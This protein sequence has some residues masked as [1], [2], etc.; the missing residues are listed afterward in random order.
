MEFGPRLLSFPMARLVRRAG[1]DCSAR[2]RLSNCSVSAHQATGRPLYTC[3]DTD[4]D[5][6]KDIWPAIW[7]KVGDCVFTS[8]TQAPLHHNSWGTH[9]VTHLVLPLPGL[10]RLQDLQQL[11][12]TYNQQHPTPPMR[13]PRRRMLC[14]QCHPTRRLPCPLC[15]RHHPH[16]RLQPIQCK[17]W[18]Q[19]WQAWE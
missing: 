12:L 13:G 19:R 4:P 10:P 3:C 8:S 14:S 15:Q 11:R 2:T 5:F 6:S 1:Q 9:A 18:R 16:S 17:L 7:L